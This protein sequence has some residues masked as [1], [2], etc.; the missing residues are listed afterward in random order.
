MWYLCEDSDELSTSF[1][2]LDAADQMV[3]LSRARQAV[4]GWPDATFVRTSVEASG[5]TFPVEAVNEII[6]SFDG[7]PVPIPEF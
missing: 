2:L 3:R 1:V 5:A 7:R 6:S 4:N